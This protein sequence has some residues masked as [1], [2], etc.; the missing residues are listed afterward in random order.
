MVRILPYKLK[1]LY[2]DKKLHVD[3]VTVLLKNSNPFTSYRMYCIANDI[4]ERQ[5][6]F[7]L[8]DEKYSITSSIITKPALHGEA[9]EQSFL[10]KIK[11]Q[12]PYYKVKATV[13]ENSSRLEIFRF[14]YTTSNQKEIYNLIPKLQNKINKLWIVKN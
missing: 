4:I 1:D 8:E 9:K 11:K 3:T 14:E 5:E 7:E 10:F 13:T 12:T 6:L 2:I